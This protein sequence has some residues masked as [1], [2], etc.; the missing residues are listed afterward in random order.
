VAGVAWRRRVF[1]GAGGS[2]QSGRRASRALDPWR[3]RGREKREGRE[4]RIE[5]EAGWEKQVA[6]ARGRRRAR[7]G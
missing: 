3:G 1:L 4:G 7:L 5:R 6:A 2:R